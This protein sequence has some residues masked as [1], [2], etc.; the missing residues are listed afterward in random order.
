L[1]EY[2]LIEKSGKILMFRTRPISN[3]M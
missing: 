2:N 1:R 3:H